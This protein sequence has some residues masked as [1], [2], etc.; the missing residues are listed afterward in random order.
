MRTLSAMVIAVSMIVACGP[1][2]P[3]AGA[4]RADW[5]VS[6]SVGATHL[7]V[8]GNQVAQTN[9]SPARLAVTW[10]TALEASLVVVTAAGNPVMETK[11]PS[12]GARALQLSLAGA[13]GVALPA[14]NYQ[15]VLRAGA[16]EA[17]VA[18]EIVHCA[19]YY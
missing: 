13:D 17:R 12:S 3:A 9:A 14:G 5:P 16:E 2:C 1:K 7:E 4:T 19:L 15:L 10:S 8:S 11:L 18:F 6:S